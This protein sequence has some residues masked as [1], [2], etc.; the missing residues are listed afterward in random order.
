LSDTLLVTGGSGFIGTNLIEAAMSRF[1]GRV[2]LD[3]KPPMNPEHASCHVSGDIL[4]QAQTLEVF[5]KVRPTH[6]VHLAARCDCDETTTV[7]AGY[8]AN[9]DGTA[10]VLKAVREAGSVRRLVVASTQFVFN[11]GAQLPASDTD[12]HPV[13]VY[14]QSKVVTE[15]LTRDA[16]LE[17]CWTLIRPTNVW[18]PWHIRYTREFFRILRAGLYV[19]PGGE[20]VVRSYA[21]VGNVVD[22]ILAILDAAESRVAGRTLY[23]GDVP[24]DIFDWVDGFSRSL[25]D[26]PARKVPRF[27]LRPVAWTGDLISL[28][29]GRPFF[30]TS[31]R[32]RSMT[33][34]YLTPMNK[35][36]EVLGPPRHDL[37]DGIR[38]TTEWLRW[39]E[40]SGLKIDDRPMTA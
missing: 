3:L 24:R 37:G 18:G 26:R 30:L 17:C 21:Y 5:R 4:N 10:N 22:Q 7:E 38:K 6:V 1:P 8:R 33:L 2:N 15:R 35:T 23:L 20:P 11:K 34:P 39:F 31:S 29:T 14:G 25:R 28:I 27:L 9:T 16:G 36:F 32:L 13:T 40:A 12:Y 19:H